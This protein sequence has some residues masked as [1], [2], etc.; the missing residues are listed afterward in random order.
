[1][2]FKR[3][4]ERQIRRGMLV[5]TLPLVVPGHLSAAPPSFPWSPWC[6]ANTGTKYPTYTNGGPATWTVGDQSLASQGFTYW[7]DAKKPSGASVVPL[8]ATDPAILIFRGTETG[9]PHP[10]ESSPWSPHDH[11]HDGWDDHI[12]QTDS[13]CSKIQ[14]STPINSA[15]IQRTAAHEL[16]HGLGVRHTGAR[17]TR[18]RP[19]SFG[20]GYYDV[21]S[22]GGIPL[23]NG[24]CLTAPLYN[25]Q[26]DDWGAISHAVMGTITAESG[27]ESLNVTGQV[28]RGD[29][30]IETFSPFQGG[31]YVSTPASGSVTQ[32]MRVYNSGSPTFRMSA[33]YKY[34]G[35]GSANFKTWGK[36][37]TYSPWECGS[38]SSVDPNW[39]EI[40]NFSVGPSSS[41]A[42][43][44]SPYGTSWGQGTYELELRI[45]N[46]SNDRLYVDN[47]YLYA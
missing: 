37:L 30:T 41:W 17:D 13:A 21:V 11:N 18:Q 36:R 44:S 9:P 3:T 12:S 42:S 15:G 33:K 7:K 43:F 47:A 35:S 27:F 24:N 32:R 46:G 4:F 19:G 38:V 8:S 26:P 34:A 5:A 20:A 29:A 31:R 23:V 22:D 45:V 40:Q 16:G 6:G 10:T 2:S 14:I 1:M 28:W 39:F 25:P